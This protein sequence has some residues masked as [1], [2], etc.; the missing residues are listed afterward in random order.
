MQ[1]PPAIAGRRALL[2]VAHP[3]HELRVHGWLELVRPQVWVLTDG[4]GHGEQGRLAST[5]RLLARAG[6]ARGPLYGRFSDRDAY[7]LM[8]RGDVAAA[9]EL[10]TVL[11]D[12]L[13]SQRIDY[14]VGD[15]CEGFN[16]VHDLCRLVIDAAVVTAARRGGR[17][18]DDFEFALDGGPA[19]QGSGEELSWQLDE[20]ALARKLAAARDYPELADEVKRA[21][22]VFGEQAF[23]RE[24]LFR[25]EPFAT[26]DSRF[27]GRPAYERH[28]EARVE[29]GLYTRVL[30]HRAHFAPLAE[31]VAVRAQRG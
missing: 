24:R 1:L 6:A 16:P 23:A 9:G 25:V 4:S 7:A 5:A 14:V 20:E 19:W 17:P 21:V 31:A 26:L 29:A 8:M 12:T 11:A 28:G 10:V 18:V 3:G 2:V 27:E 13:L 22:A 15:A 30:R